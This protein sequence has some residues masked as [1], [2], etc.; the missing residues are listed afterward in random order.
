[1]VGS[2]GD[3]GG[4]LLLLGSAQG[5]V[6]RGYADDLRTAAASASK[7]DAAD[8]CVDATGPDDVDFDVAGDTPHQVN[9][10]TEAGQSAGVEHRI[11]VGINDLNGF[12]SSVGLPI[13][14][15]EGELM[16]VAVGKIHVKAESAAAIPR[17]GNSART[18]PGLQ[19]PGIGGAGEP[20]VVE[21]ILNGQGSI[22]RDTLRVVG[23]GIS[24][25]SVDAMPTALRTGIGSKEVCDGQGYDDS[26][27]RRVGGDGVSR[28][29]AGYAH[30]VY[31]RRAGVGGD[32]HRHGDWGKARSTVQNVAPR[33]TIGRTRPSGAG[34][35]DQGQARGDGL[36]YS[37]RSASGPGICPVRD[38]HGIRGI[39]LTLSEAASVRF[40]DAERWW[41][42][43]RGPVV[44]Q[45]G[46]VDGADAGGE[47]PA[48]GGA[49]GGS[50]GSIGS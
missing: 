23:H 37:H 20:S 27:R 17:R 18:A 5:D 13:H 34:H 25:G 28:A 30:P 2:A 43:R 33:A 4:E 42:R 47:V 12:R 7:E 41:I 16:E 14:G 29:T 32:I 39:L 1:M 46:G 48:D 8:D 44:D 10:I 6:L 31:Q 36:G 26:N 50:E 38:R 24:I 11:G 9:A 19:C 35:R 22:V 49:V 40:R 21:L 3:R 45:V 15:V